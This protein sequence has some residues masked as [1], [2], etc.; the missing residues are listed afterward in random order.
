MTFEALTAPYRRELLQHCYRMAG[1]IHDA[2]DLLQETLI[3]AWRAFDRYDES[4]ASLRTW[5]YRIAT[6]TCLTELEGRS[7][8]PLPSGLV[9]EGE[10]PAGPLVRGD[11]VLW[12]QPFPADP[13][14]VVGAKGSL[15]LALI[16]AL[17]FLPAKQ[18]AVLILREVLDWSAA[19]IAAALDLTPAAVNSA[20]QRARAKLSETGLVEDDVLEPDD[21]RSTELVA[22]YITAFERADVAAFAELLTAEVVLEMPPFYNWFQG[23][24]NHLRFV[25]GVFARRGMDW[26]VLPIEANGQA[27]IAVYRGEGAVHRLHTLHVFTITAAG[28][29]HNRVFQDDGVFAAFGLAPVL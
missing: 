6:N 1:S 19:E 9:A 25:E 21:P 12:L 18:R 22:K 2:E 14:A 26:R 15:R 13:A 16:A 4:R 29:S 17:Q 11:E 27:G 28:I 10:D 7:R 20:L 24:D 3:R 23:R 5:L 8:R